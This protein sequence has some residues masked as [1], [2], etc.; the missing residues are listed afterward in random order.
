MTDKDKNTVL[1]W[2]VAIAVVIILMQAAKADD[3]VHCYSNGDG[4]VSCER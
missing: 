1:G 4:T 2:I 3:S